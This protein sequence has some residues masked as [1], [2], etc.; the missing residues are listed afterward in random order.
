[1]GRRCC[2]RNLVPPASSAPRRRPL[3]V[4]SQPICPVAVSSQ[5]VLSAPL[6]LSTVLP[7][8][9]VSACDLRNSPGSHGDRPRGLSSQAGRSF[10]QRGHRL[11]SSSRGCSLMTEK[12]KESYLV[13]ALVRPRTELVFSGNGRPHQASSETDEPRPAVLEE[14]RALVTTSGCCALSLPPYRRSCQ[15]PRIMFNEVRGY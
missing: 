4:A 10:R 14:L 9:D 6:P 1:M 5:R 12:Q 13:D 15:V 7:Q 2:A 3:P 11:C 8:R